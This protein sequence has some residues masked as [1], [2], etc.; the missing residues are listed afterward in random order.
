[1][2]NKG[3]SLTNKTEKSADAVSPD[4]HDEAMSDEFPE[5]RGEARVMSALSLTHDLPD[6]KRCLKWKKKKR[7]GVLAFNHSLNVC[8]QKKRR[9]HHRTAISSY[10][11]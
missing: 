3:L 9:P 7:E 8:R 5:G 4:E 6:V 10:G 2:G 1:V 11:L